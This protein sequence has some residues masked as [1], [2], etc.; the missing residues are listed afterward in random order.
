MSPNKT[1]QILDHTLGVSARVRTAIGSMGCM[2][3]GLTVITFNELNP[4]INDEANG[5]R[6]SLARCLSMFY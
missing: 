6:V 3:M 1:L 5:I 2:S 4:R